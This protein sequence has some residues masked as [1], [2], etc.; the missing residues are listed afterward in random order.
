MREPPGNLIKRGWDEGRGD[1]GGLDVGCK[2]LPSKPGFFRLASLMIFSLAARRDANFLPLT[3]PSSLNPARGTTL[4]FC[5]FTALRRVPAPRIRHAGKTSRTQGP[6]ETASHSNR[7]TMAVPA[8]WIACRV[9]LDD[10]FVRGDVAFCS[11]RMGLGRL[12]WC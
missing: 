9:F 3:L 11:R 7:A 1:T 10:L 12:Q 2:K 4:A 6:T 8:E 5:R